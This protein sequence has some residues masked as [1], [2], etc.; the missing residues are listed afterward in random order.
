M[1]LGNETLQRQLSGMLRRGVLSHCLLLTGPE[2]SGK[3]KLALEIAMALECEQPRDGTACGQCAECRRVR[4]GIHPDVI[5]VDFDTVGKA[6]GYAKKGQVAYIRAEV[7]ADAAIKPNQGHRKIYH[8]LDADKL[9][10]SSQNALLKLIEEPPAYGVFLLESRNPDFLLPT[11]RSRATELRLEPLPQKL[12]EREL[13]QRCP[14]SSAEAR[15]VALRR[16]GGWLG[17]AIAVA[18]S[19]GGVLPEV[20]ALLRAMASPR[21]RE[22]VLRACVPMEKYKRDQLLP[23]LEQ[24]REGFGEALAIRRAGATGLS[25]RRILAAAVTARQ[26]SRAADAVQIA[27]DR[28]NGNVNA[29]HVVGALSVALGR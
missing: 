12:L 11:V 15:S 26:L 2:G 6:A 7:C 1:L 14:E 3:S 18:E 10:S 29:A 8:I 5:S 21:R 23:I 28:L 27:I 13:L 19:G 22:A 16:C 25:D 17:Q 9:N 20:E 4:H 24:L